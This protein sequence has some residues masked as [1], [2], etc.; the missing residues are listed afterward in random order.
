VPKPRRLLIVIADGEHVRFVRPGQDNTLH[1]GTT[2]DSLAAHKRSGKLISDHP[3]ASFH[4]GST[5]HH[6]LAPRHD[7]HALEQ[8]KFTRLIAEQLNAGAARGEFDGLVIAAPPHILIAI[9]K[10]LNTATDATIVGT[11]QK[12]LIKTPDNELRPHV[13]AWAPPVRR[14]A[15]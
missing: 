6:A 2:L 9:R 11:I 3:G 13:G 7:P 12:D 15:S 10:D 1:T 5:A 14:A 4:T 8:A